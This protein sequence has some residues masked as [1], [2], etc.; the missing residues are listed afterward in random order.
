VNTIGVFDQLSWYPKLPESTQRTL[1]R[2][3][4]VQEYRRER[5]LFYQG[6]DADTVYLVLAGQVKNVKWRDA[7]TSFLL[8]VSSPGAW[9][10][11]PEA[12]VSG[13][14]LSD[15]ETTDD[16]LLGLLT[17]TDLGHLGAMPGIHELF[18]ETLAE[19]HHLLHEVIELRSAESK[20]AR[21]L[22]SA[23]DNQ[24]DTPTIEVTQ[25]Q[26]AAMTGVTRETVNKQ[27]SML[28]DRGLV[29]KERGRLLIN[30]VDGL[31]RLAD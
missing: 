5:Q 19:G 23:L 27:L 14:Y 15:A 30:D 9:L 3:F 21:F 16:S 4:R 26:I 7:G 17:R 24:A 29:S 2:F 10:G 20:I 12:S 13:T 18:I 8:G 31:E 28:Q 6:D 1:Q 25:H 22:I 11:L